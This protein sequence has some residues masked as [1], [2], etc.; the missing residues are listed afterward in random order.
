MVRQGLISITIALVPTLSEDESDTYQ[1]WYLKQSCDNMNRWR[2]TN[3]WVAR[4]RHSLNGSGRRTKAADSVRMEKGHHI[5]VL[6]IDNPSI[7]MVDIA[8][9]PGSSVLVVWA[10]YQM[11]IFSNTND[12]QLFDWRMSVRVRWKWIVTLVHWIL[13]FSVVRTHRTCCLILWCPLANSINARRVWMIVVCAIWI[14]SCSKATVKRYLRRKSWIL[15]SEHILTVWTSTARKDRHTI[16]GNAN[17][18]ICEP[19]YLKKI[20]KPL[21]FVISVRLCPTKGIIEGL[22]VRDWE[23]L[24]VN[25]H[26]LKGDLEIDLVFLWKRITIGDFKAVVRVRIG[27]YSDEGHP[28]VL[29][30]GDA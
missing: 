16:S 26:R 19:L 3:S 2:E 28:E 6:T 12:F 8:G 22:F 20:I 18:L 24:E 21:N 14:S 1:N 23:S 10:I 30:A 25:S 13:T 5:A 17:N 11:S 15:R 4:A 29:P 27:L 9:F 7:A